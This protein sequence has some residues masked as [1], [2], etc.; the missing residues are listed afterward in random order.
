MDLEKRRGQL[1]EECTALD[2]V[3]KKSKQKEVC[4]ILLSHFFLCFSILPDKIVCVY[5]F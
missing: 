5:F 2:G 4:I 3:L 1:Q